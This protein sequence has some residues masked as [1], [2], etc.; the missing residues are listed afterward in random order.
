MQ[1]EDYY[2]DA[3]CGGCCPECTGSA[4]WHCPHCPHHRRTPGAEIPDGYDY[5]HLVGSPGKRHEEVSDA[6]P[7]DDLLTDYDRV[8]LGYGMQISWR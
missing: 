1:F 7:F 4:V 3:V 6:V 2:S 8:L 5:S